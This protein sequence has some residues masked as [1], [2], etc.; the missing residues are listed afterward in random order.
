[1]EGK[2]EG[3]GLTP[4]FDCF[5]STYA[6]DVSGALVTGSRA[7][8]FDA[9][10]RP[11][12][13]TGFQFI[14]ATLACYRVTVLL[15]RDIGPFK[16]LKKFRSIEP[17]FLGCPFCMSMYVAGGIEAAF[18]FSGVRDSAIVIACI[19]LSM[20]AITIAL[21]RAFTSDHNPQ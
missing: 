8:R 5:E 17:K 10:W 14:I 2:S 7:I 19:V 3:N 4:N 21:D 6:G 20:S 13:M 15:T 9:N 11:D 1:M 12:F 18:F 16:I